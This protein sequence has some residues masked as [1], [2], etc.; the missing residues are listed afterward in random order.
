MTY[1]VASDFHQNVAALDYIF[2]N[3]ADTQIVLLGDF[4]DTHDEKSVSDARDMADHLIQHW[5]AADVKPIIVTGNHDQFI[6]GSAFMDDLEFQ[7]WMINGGKQTLRQLGYRGAK[8]LYQVS[9]FLN[10]RYPDL[11]AV[12]KSGRYIVDEPNIVFVHAG[13]DWDTADPIQD[14]APDIATWI[15]EGYLF[16]SPEA[17][18]RPH[19][20]P[21]GKTIVSGHTPIQNFSRDKDDIW[22]MHHADDLPG[23][24]RYLIDGGAGTGEPNAHVNIVQFDD[25]GRLISQ[26]AFGL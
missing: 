12:L 11:L 25:Y 22:V 23:V 7:T 5:H 16:E 18:S 17:H 24:N 1:T 19:Y 20:N 13:L 10:T 9:D 8:S 26:E 15:R 2:E 6:I 14:T 4:F 3:Y 21:T